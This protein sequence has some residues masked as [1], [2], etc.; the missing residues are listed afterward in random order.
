MPPK[1]QHSVS[2]RYPGLHDFCRRPDTVLRTKMPLSHSEPG[3]SKQHS[4][5]SVIQQSVS[6]PTNQGLLPM[7]APLG[8]SLL[9]KSRCPLRF[10]NFS[11]T[12]YS[13]KPKQNLVLVTASSEMIPTCSLDD[14]C[15]NYYFCSSCLGGQSPC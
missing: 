15:I 9:L 11:M 12:I 7:N 14:D 10:F 13:V 1:P 2:Q 6:H 3:L 5:T 8:E 4:H